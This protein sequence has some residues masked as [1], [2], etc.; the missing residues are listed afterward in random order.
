M[1][2]EDSE[3]KGKTINQ[4]CVPARSNLSEQNCNFITV[5]S[6]YRKVL[7]FHIIK[8]PT[9]KVNLVLYNV[10]VYCILKL[11]NKVLLL[12]SALISLYFQL[13]P[14]RMGEKFRKIVYTTLWNEIKLGSVFDI[15]QNDIFLRI[16]GRL[17]PSE[18]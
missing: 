15:K 11:E 4:C 3:Y 2:D 17:R 6:K 8:D 9:N 1:I 18:L 7:Y 14:K 10:N 12:I 13:Y 5:N 16:S